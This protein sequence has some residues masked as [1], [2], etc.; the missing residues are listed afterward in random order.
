MT[1][2]CYLACL[3]IHRAERD[4]FAEIA[5]VLGVCKASEWW[6]ASKWAGKRDS[7]KIHNKLWFWGLK[8]WDKEFPSWEYRVRDGQINHKNFHLTDL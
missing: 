1:K 8:R 3:A 5:E 4:S 6:D 7:G 2:L